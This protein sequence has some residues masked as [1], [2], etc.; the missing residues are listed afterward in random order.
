MKFTLDQ[1][2]LLSAAQEAF[3]GSYIELDKVD[4]YLP[5]IKEGVIQ[6]EGMDQPLYVSTNY[7]YEDRIVIGNNTRYKV[8]LHLITIKKDRYEVIYDSYG[9]SFIAYEKDRI[10]FTPYEDFHE[11]IKKIMKICESEK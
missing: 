7:V 4:F 11:E 3:P 10:L 5:D 9:K 6:L 2:R 1:D 8:E